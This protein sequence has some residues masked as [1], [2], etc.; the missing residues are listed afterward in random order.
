LFKVTRHFQIGVE[1]DV[2][3]DRHQAGTSF[4]FSLGHRCSDRTLDRFR[5]YIFFYRSPSLSFPISQFP[6]MIFHRSSRC[7]LRVLHIPETNSDRVPAALRINIILL[8][9]IHRPVYFSKQRFGDWILSPFSG[10]T[11]SVGPN[12]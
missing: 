12:R 5:Q 6:V 9:I 10:K 1:D 3:A 2:F 8:D 11:Y 4:L 7:I